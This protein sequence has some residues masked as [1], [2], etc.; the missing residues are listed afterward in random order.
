MKS[1]YLSVGGNGGAVFIAQPAISISANTPT[2][3]VTAAPVLLPPSNLLPTSHFQL[4][5][6][7]VHHRKTLDESARNVRLDDDSSVGGDVADDARDAIQTANLLPVE[8]L[9]AVERNRHTPR[10]ERQT[11]GNHLQQLGDARPLC[12]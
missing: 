5:T 1:G 12:R 8:L 9:A 4:P 6:S 7:F 11:R 10:V 3:R 2:H